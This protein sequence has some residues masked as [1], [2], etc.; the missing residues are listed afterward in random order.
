MKIWSIKILDEDLERLAT[1]C[2]GCSR[3]N[4]PNRGPGFWGWFCEA[5]DKERRGAGL[6]LQN[7]AGFW[8]SVRTFP[9]DSQA[10]D[11]FNSHIARLHR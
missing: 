6:T 10:L 9:T 2:D 1:I 3:P 8:F 11:D 4:D 7:S 5:C